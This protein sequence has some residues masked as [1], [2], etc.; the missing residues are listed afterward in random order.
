MLVRHRQP[1]YLSSAVNSELG[2]LISHAYGAQH[3][4]PAADIATQ[5]HDVIITLE[6]PGL[7]PNDIDITLDG[8]Q[9]TI[10]GERD[11]NT[12]AEGDRLISRGTRRGRFNRT[13]T[14][15]LGTTHE[16]VTANLENGLLRVRVAEVTKPETEPHK[17]TISSGDQETALES[18]ETA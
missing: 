7:S 4:A 2:R 14:V 9:L 12:L 11:T 8:R 16:Q 17:I 3:D 6:V 15:P 10:S 1:W 13:F 18:R 5:G